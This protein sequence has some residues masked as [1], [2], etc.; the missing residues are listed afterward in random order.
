M[1]AKKATDGG[2]ANYFS[3]RHFSLLVFPV[4]V[5]ING[6]CPYLGLKT[7]SS[8][9]MF[10]N[11]RTEGGVTNHY[12][13]PIELQIFG[14][15]KDAVEFISSSDPNLQKLADNNQL[16]VYQKFKSYF[17][18]K[19]PAMVEYIRN[20]NRY[21]YEAGN[22]ELYNELTQ[23]NPLLRKLFDFRHFSKDGPQPCAH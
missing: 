12:F 7:E 15:Q 17:S 23:V 13:M 14:Y 18:D 2:H 16:L 22:A 1:F 9:A 4:I 20:G 6:M 3:A 21:R 11:L 5:F 8:F 10:S 19:K